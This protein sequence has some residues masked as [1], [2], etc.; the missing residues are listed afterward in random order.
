M[1]PASRWDLKRAG[2][3]AVLAGQ[4]LRAAAARGEIA[5]DFACVGQRGRGSSDFIRHS[6]LAGLRDGS[7]DLY[8]SQP[9]ALRA[10][11]AKDFVHRSIYG[12]FMPKCRTQGVDRTQTGHA[13]YWR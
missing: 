6:E 12:D 5:R 1:P 2:T 9:S 3:G 10:A 8:S 4:A 11:S 7:M 13:I